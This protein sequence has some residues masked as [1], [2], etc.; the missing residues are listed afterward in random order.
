MILDQCNSVSS[1]LEKRIVICKQEVR[2][3]SALL[4]Y[5]D[6]RR[7]V[8]VTSSTL[9]IMHRNVLIIFLAACMSF[10]EFQRVRP[11]YRYV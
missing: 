5:Y 4:N 8:V 3:K 9:R 2:E 7:S 10:E 1:F 11:S 6:Y